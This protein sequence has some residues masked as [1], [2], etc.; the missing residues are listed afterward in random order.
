MSRAVV[1]ALAALAAAGCHKAR[2]EAVVVVQTAGV[3]IPDDVASIRLLVEDRASTGDDPLYDHT[4]PL[5]TATLTT[6]CYQLPLSA[7]LF[8]GAKQ[9]SDSVRVEVDAVSQTGVTVTADAAL[10]T[11]AAGE[12]LRLDFVLYQNCIG[13]TN[14]A[15]RDQACGSDAMC[16][17]VPIVPFQGEPDL[18]NGG[19]PP[20]SDMAVSGTG[21]D[22]TVP[23]PPGSDLSAPPPDLTSSLDMSGCTG[24]L[25][26]PMM[27]CV[28]G[29]CVSCGGM[30]DP[31]CGL[32][33]PSRGGGGPSH[34]RSGGTPMAG[35]GPGTC[36]PGFA[37]D[38]T[39]CVPCG[40]PNALCCMPP[41][42]PCNFGGCLGNGYCPQMMPP[43]LMDMTMI[44]PPPVD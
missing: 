17:P 38:G 23:P 13:V 19:V 27:T 40:A 34:V 6:G 42:P 44:H 41:A 20:S 4:V 1:V 3:R 12:S 21:P 2:T 24:V 22:M 25:C 28:A 5:C 18:G 10:F 15:A 33:G 11:F 35:G 8:P 43:P 39:T 32:S 37:C 9:G 16:A 31:C 26:P 29:G 30:G 14:C 7:V 36:N